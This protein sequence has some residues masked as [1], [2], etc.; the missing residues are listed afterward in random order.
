MAWHLG[1]QTEFRMFRNIW[2]QW[3]PEAVSGDFDN[4][5]LILRGELLKSLASR[6]L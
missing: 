5:R 2:P 4:S 3:K 1:V 6:A